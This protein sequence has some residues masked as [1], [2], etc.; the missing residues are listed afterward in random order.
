MTTHLTLAFLL[1]AA[2]AGAC[3]LV[4]AWHGWGH[5]TG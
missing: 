3:A 5:R 1:L 4:T 2:A